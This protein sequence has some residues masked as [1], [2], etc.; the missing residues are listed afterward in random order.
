MS[1]PWSRTV[2][3]ALSAEGAHAALHSAWPRRSVLAR[4]SF[5]ADATP[6]TAL[7]GTPSSASTP[8]PLVEAI[9]AV[10]AELALVAPL[11]GARLTVEFADDRTHLDVVAGDHSGASERQLG[12]IAAACIAELLEDAAADHIVRWQLQ[13]DLQHLLISALPRREVEMLVQAA[14]RHGLNLT[15]LQPSFCVQWNRHAGALPGGTGVWS[16]ACHSHAVVVW[17]NAGAVQAIRSG[18]WPAQPRGGWPDPRGTENPL[19]AQVDRLLASQGLDTAQIPAFVLVAPAL[20]E[21]AVA[22]R[23]TVIDRQMELA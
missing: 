8:A 1:R 15:S 21:Q 22:A 10:L 23:W 19:D 16:L 11:R 12:A 13:P 17:A 18:P 7:P 5:A 20:P 4:A 6:P 9:D 14:A 2:S 3:L